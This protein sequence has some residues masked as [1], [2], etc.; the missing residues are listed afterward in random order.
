MSG[1][2]YVVVG[3]G[4]S[5][6]AKDARA[7]AL[8]R[9]SSDRLRIM[10]VND[11]VYPLW[12]ADIAYA[13]DAQWWRAHR[14]LPGF[15]GTKYRIFA[16][17]ECPEAVDPLPEYPD[18]FSY[19]SSG[20]NGYDPRVG[21]IRHGRNGGYQAIHIAAQ[22][23]AARIVLVGFDMRGDR[24]FGS[25]V[26]AAVKAGTPPWQTWVKWMLEL[27]AEVEKLGV[28]VVNTSPS[29]ALRPMTFAQLQDELD[30]A[31]RR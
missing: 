30:A 17:D 20:R 27:I 21:Y 24:W 13:G 28:T 7:I 8:A 3:S 23:G 22:Q 5:F 1:R 12:M 26:K 31:T 16:P 9:L 25:H 15:A 29:S 19:V 14:G 18:V 11:A 4:G 6:T 2:T 10:T